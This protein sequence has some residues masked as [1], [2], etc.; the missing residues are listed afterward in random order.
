MAISEGDISPLLRGCRPAASGIPMYA[1]R[2]QK[3]TGYLPPRRLAASSRT[4]KH[5][6]SACVIMLCLVTMSY[7]W[8]GQCS[9]VSTAH[10]PS[11]STSLTVSVGRF[12][13][14]R[15]S[16]GS[17]PSLGFGRVLALLWVRYACYSVL[18]VK[19]VSLRWSQHHLLCWLPIWH[20][21]EVTSNEWVERITN[22]RI[23]SP[24]TCEPPSMSKN[25]ASVTLRFCK[26]NCTCP[27]LAVLPL[28]DW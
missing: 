10:D 6:L 25:R 16:L 3:M 5:H 15:N 11:M 8:R 19:R 23:Q 2:Q 28:R 17:A 22:T 21:F 18:P 20:P 26:G 24:Q 9:G 1:V 4:T 13:S 14:E 12:C 27:N 7:A